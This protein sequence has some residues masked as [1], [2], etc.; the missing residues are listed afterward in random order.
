M[1]SKLLFYATVFLLPLNLGLHFEIKAAYVWGLLID[2]LVPTVFV[3][4]ILVALLLVVFVFEQRGRFKNLVYGLFQERRFQFLIFFLFTVLLSCF[5]AVRFVPSIYA[6][7][8]LFLYALFSVYVYLEV[9]ARDVKVAGKVFLISMLFVSLLG[10]AQFFH[11]GAIFNNYLFFG[12]QPYSNATPFIAKERLLGKLYLPAYGLFRHPNVF[13]AFLVVAVL[14]VLYLFRTKNERFSPK[15]GLWI[16]AL[17]T[18]LIALFFTFS[19]I[20]WA[21]LLLGLLLSGYNFSRFNKALFVLI[22]VIPLLLPLV[23]QEIPFN[24]IPSIDRRVVLMQAAY[25][26]ITEKPFFG[27][28]YNNITIYIESYIQDL[29]DIRFTQPIHNIFALVFAESGF[30]AFIFFVLF[31]FSSFVAQ[32][33]SRLKVLCLVLLFLAGFDH[34]FLT[35]HQAQLL[36]FGVFALHDV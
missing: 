4:D 21:A 6:F 10:I 3:Q 11:K 15:E 7:G 9:G 35:A 5:G 23:K 25:K 20:S 19:F 2:Y 22:L 33:N 30:Y 26:M 29:S 13:G 12:E 28:G 31:L 24:K 8:R 18:L 34:Y 32:K 27:F 16:V 36:F 1:R 17:G 14:V